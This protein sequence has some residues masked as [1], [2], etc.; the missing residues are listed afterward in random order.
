MKEMIQLVWAGA[1]LVALIALLIECA[2]W[3][4]GIKSVLNSWENNEVKR[5]RGFTFHSI[6][7]SIAKSIVLSP[8]YLESVEDPGY[9]VFD[10]NNAYCGTI[11]SKWGIMW[12][13]DW[14]HQVKGKKYISLQSVQLASFSAKTTIIRYNSDYFFTI[15][16][17]GTDEEIDMVAR[18]QA[19]LQ[20]KFR[21]L[22]T[23]VVDHIRSR[24]AIDPMTNIV[25]LAVAEHRPITLAEKSELCASL[26]PI[27]AELRKLY[28]IR[29]TDVAFGSY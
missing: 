19:M 14:D 7:I 3:S 27:D 24:A 16:Y 20:K 29:L 6:V 11:R 4:D 28:S 25:K 1:Y 15:S 9:A 17:L 2:F 26:T 22:N 23:L 5:W 21:D 13:S 8:L 18:S 10:E 12:Q